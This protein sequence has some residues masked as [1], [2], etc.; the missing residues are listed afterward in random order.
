MK[1]WDS[2]I[3]S[4]P[5]GLDFFYYNS[6]TSSTSPTA[7]M[8]IQSICSAIGEDPS[9]PDDA[10]PDEA[11]EFDEEVLL[12][13]PLLDDVDELSVTPPTPVE[14]RHLSF[15][16][17]VASELKVM[18]AHCGECAC[19]QFAYFLAHKWLQCD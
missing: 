6:L 13:P 10:V 5:R 11:V 12:P 2:L 8:V 16:R 7:A 19:Q 4:K 15:P 18:S 17:I 9:A 1:S 14:L 3:Q